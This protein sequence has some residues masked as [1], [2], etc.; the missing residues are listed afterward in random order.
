M[1]IVNV[2]VKENSRAAVWTSFSQVYH[3]LNKQDYYSEH[4]CPRNTF[5]RNNRLAPRIIVCYLKGRAHSECFAIH[6]CS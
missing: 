4:H 5:R 6:R 1:I 2:F 3:R